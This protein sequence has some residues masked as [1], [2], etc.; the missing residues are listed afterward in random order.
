MT[1]L[2]KLIDTLDAFTTAHYQLQ[3]FKFEFAGELQPFAESD[4]TFPILFAEIKDSSTRDGVDVYKL[5]LT[6]LDRIQND[7]TNTLTNMSDTS[8]ILKD[9]KKYFNTDDVDNDIFVLNNINCYPQNNYTTAK[10]QGYYADFDFEVSSFNKCDIPIGSMPAG[11]KA[12]LD[13]TVVNS[14]TSFEDTVESGSTLTLSDI[15][16]ST[17]FTDLT[18]PAAIDI[19]MSDYILEGGV[20]TV[21]ANGELVDTVDVGDT[22][23]LNIIYEN[24]DVVP[25]TITGSNIIVP[26]VVVLPSNLIYIRPEPT[27]EVYVAGTATYPNGCDSWRVFTGTDISTQP[28]MGIPML[29]NKSKRYKIIPDN[30]FN[31]KWRYTG[32]TGGYWDVETSQYKNASGGVVDYATAFPDNY[33]IDHSTGLGWQT[34]ANN[35]NVTWA[36]ALTEIDALT[37]ASFNDWFL[38]NLNEM[39]SVADYGYLAT[40]GSTGDVNPIWN[41]AIT[42][43]TKW[44]ATTR[45]GFNERA[46]VVGTDA[47]VYTGFVKI[48]AMRYMA[49]RYHFNNL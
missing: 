4:I 19:D 47:G 13:A 9:I 28:T 42:N 49:C 5:K 33:L 41:A 24:T 44:T 22:L 11:G 20:A 43:G 16:V 7:R 37:F 25:I 23:N 38:P 6:V 29:I 36:V 26:D 17:K 15:T 2:T 21:N 45:K 1:T 3:R 48:N 30:T 39:T 8:L 31:H 27:G 35:T 12:C 18:F 34:V 46:W 32:K 40:L 14:D 10:L